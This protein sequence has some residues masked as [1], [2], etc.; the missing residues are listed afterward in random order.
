MYKKYRLLVC[1]GLLVLLSI[2]NGCSVNEEAKKVYDDD[3]IIAKESDTY[4]LGPYSSTRTNNR[5]DLNY[6]RFN[7]S[8]TLFYLESEESAEVRI[9]YDSK[10]DSGNFKAVLI[11]PDKEL[12]NL[13]SGNEN[14]SIILSLEKGTS[15]FKIVG[16]DANGEINISI[17]TDQDVAIISHD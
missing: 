17:D 3:S 9:D 6:S 13:L 2:T 16:K 7:G 12:Q 10:V 15:R 14:G 5:F 11:D 8:Y 4:S 1:L